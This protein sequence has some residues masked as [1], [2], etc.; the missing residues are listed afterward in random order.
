MSVINESFWI[1]GGVDNSNS[2]YVSANT[3]YL[4]LDG[5]IKS[6]SNLPG[7]ASRQYSLKI[8]TLIFFLA[9]SI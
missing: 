6:G 8:G 2:L 4:N 1:T 3:E 9:K 7:W 5:F